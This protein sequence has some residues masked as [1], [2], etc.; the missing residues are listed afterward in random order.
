MRPLSGRRRL[1]AVVSAYACVMLCYCAFFAAPVSPAAPL[2]AFS[3]VMEEG[4]YSHF[5]HIHE[6]LYTNGKAFIGVAT[7]RTISAPSA[8]YSMAFERLDRYAE[9][10]AREQYGVEVDIAIES[11][12]TGYAFSGHEA[13]RYTYG[14]FKEITIGLPPF[15][16]TQDFKLAEIGAIAWFCNVD[17]ESVVVVYVTPAYFVDEPALQELDI[18]TMDVVA[19]FACH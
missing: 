6:T 16:T 4:V 1:A 9:D 8:A 7:I 2:D 10:F 12:E 3:F 13:V 17:F 18:R 11:S 19:S 14:V 15:E 5:P